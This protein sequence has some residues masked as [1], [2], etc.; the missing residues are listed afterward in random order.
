MDRDHYRRMQAERCLQYAEWVITDEQKQF[1]RKCAE[2][3]LKES[4]AGPFAKDD[5][6]GRRS[7][8]Q[9]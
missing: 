7:P 8:G 5:M 1:W 9:D 6:I 2:D 4:P 3:W